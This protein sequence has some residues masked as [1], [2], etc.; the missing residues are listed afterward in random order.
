MGY[1]VPNKNYLRG[2]RLE[3]E[4]VEDCINHG[5]TW[6][7][8]MA[9]SHSP[10]DVIGV[11]EANKRIVFV[12]CKTKLVKEAK[13]CAITENKEGNDWSVLMYKKTKF[14]ARRK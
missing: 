4:V 2:R 6:A 3:Y 12:Q 13:L 10:Y 14:I 11:D 5:Y 7:Q 1:I 9:G 8:R